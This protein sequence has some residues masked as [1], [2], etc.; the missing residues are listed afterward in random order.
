MIDP[1]YK[2]VL[3]VWLKDL[4]ETAIFSAIAFPVLRRL[5]KKYFADLKCPHCHK[6]FGEQAVKTHVEGTSQS[7]VAPNVPSP[8]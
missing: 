4:A 2:T 6:K 1:V 5:I 3:L 8:S 7:D